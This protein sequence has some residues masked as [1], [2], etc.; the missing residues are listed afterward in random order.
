MISSMVLVATAALTVFHPG[1]CFPEIHGEKLEPDSF[2]TSE[3][4]FQMIERGI[5]K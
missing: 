2:N 4:D 3:Q 1:Y 5:D